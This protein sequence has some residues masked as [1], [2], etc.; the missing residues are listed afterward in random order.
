MSRPELQAPPEIFYNAE[1]ATS[2][3]YNSRIIEIQSIMA[4]RCIQLLNLPDHPCLILDI[5]CGSGLSGE[6]LTEYEHMWVGMDISEHML[7]VAV[8]KKVDGDVYLN[9][10]GQGFKFRPGIFDGCISVSVLQWI[11]VASRKDQNPYKRIHVF[12]QSLYTCLAAGARAIFQF[13]P[14]G[15]EQL[16]KVISAAMKAAFKAAVI[17]DYPDS[18]RRK[19]IYLVLCAGDGDLSNIKP[20][21]S[22]LEEEGEDEME[23][24]KTERLDV[25]SKRSKK[26]Q[27]HHFKNEKPT[28]KSKKWILNKK[29]RQR[30]Q[31]KEVRK[32]T[33]YS[34]RKRNQMF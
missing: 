32:D 15:P 4:E 26:I 20:L 19:K 24:E 33:K 21:T 1:E 6:M 23:E 25:L 16:E 3:T 11:F 18:K 22:K 5:G 34:G 9:D 13:Y 28:V 7:N 10:M 30:R 29:E 14:D 31:G 2:Y 12:F 27:K 17:V 8:S